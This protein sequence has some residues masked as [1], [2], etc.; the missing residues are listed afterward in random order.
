MT[1][2]GQGTFSAFQIGRPVFTAIPECRERGRSFHGP[3]NHG[4]PW[5]FPRQRSPPPCSGAGW[6]WGIRDHGLRSPLANFT[7]GYT[8]APLWG[9]VVLAIG[10]DA[11]RLGFGRCRRSARFVA[12]SGRS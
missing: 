8:P 7:R 10:A 3:E 9:F 6:V 1:A 5:A 12:H 2:L 11:R 4:K